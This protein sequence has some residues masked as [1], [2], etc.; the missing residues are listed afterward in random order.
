MVGCAN[1]ATATLTRRFLGL[2]DDG[3]TSSSVITAEVLAEGAAE[4]VATKL[5][6]LT[7]ADT[8][9]DADADTKWSETEE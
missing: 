8:G 3:V 2:A 4:G 5:S 7:S 6:M 1:R 9:A